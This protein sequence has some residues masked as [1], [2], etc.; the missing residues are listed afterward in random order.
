MRREGEVISDAAHF[1]SVTEFLKTIVPM[2]PTSSTNFTVHRLATLLWGQT[3]LMQWLEVICWH[4]VCSPS[5][6]DCLGKVGLNL[7]L[8]PFY[9]MM[10]LS[11]CILDTCMLLAE[12]SFGTIYLLELYSGAI[13]R[14][15]IKALPLRNYIKINYI[16]G[17]ISHRTKF[18]ELSFKGTIF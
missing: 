18:Q 10:Q 17:I 13:L 11:D 2:E 12:L 16:L 15:Y 14:N 1:V 8:V 6:Q 9:F 3:P 4:L 5:T 7:T